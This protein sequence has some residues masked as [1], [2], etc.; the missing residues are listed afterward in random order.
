MWL[1]PFRE[2]LCPGEA[3]NQ[4]ENSQRATIEQYLNPREMELHRDHDGGKDEGTAEEICQSSA[5]QDYD[6]HKD[7]ADDKNRQQGFELALAAGSHF[8]VEPLVVEEK[9]YTGSNE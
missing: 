6:H 8:F 5:H 7:V 1:S 9:S 3:Q 4:E 2:Q